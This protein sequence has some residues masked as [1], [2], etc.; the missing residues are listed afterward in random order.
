MDSD[1]SATSGG[2]R[3]AAGTKTNSKSSKSNSNK[4]RKQKFNPKWLEL[5]GFKEWLRPIK[6]NE[7]KCRCDACNKDLLCGKSELKKH[8]DSKMHQ[9]ACT[10]SQPL[11]ISLSESTRANWQKSM[12]TNW[13]KQVKLLAACSARWCFTSAA[14]SVLGKCCRS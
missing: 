5:E 7:F 12:A 2:S 8:G 14:N 1:S 10:A 9:F 11:Q 3:T 4:W 6:D 13:V